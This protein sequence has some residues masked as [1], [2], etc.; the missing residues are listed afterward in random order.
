MVKKYGNAIDF[1]SSKINFAFTTR[2]FFYQDCSDSKIRGNNLFNKR[3]W[4]KWTV[5]CKTMNWIPSHQ[6]TKWYNID[7]RPKLKH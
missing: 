5:P 3:D 2:W 6:C 1:K 4:N 7:N